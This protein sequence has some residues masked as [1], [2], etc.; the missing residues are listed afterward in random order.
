MDPIKPQD[1]GH[2]LS[3]GGKGQAGGFKEMAFRNSRVT[4]EPG[5][6]FA[7]QERQERQE[8]HSATLPT[9]PSRR[10]AVAY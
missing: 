7:S 9:L 5:T 8:Q 2:Q 6:F 10:A 1:A 4:L 3:G